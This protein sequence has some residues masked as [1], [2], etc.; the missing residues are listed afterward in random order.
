MNAATAF[1]GGAVMYSPSK[2]RQLTAQRFAHDRATPTINQ[3]HSASGD[4]RSV[5]AI[6]AAQREHRTLPD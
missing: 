4:R 1:V 2:R 3:A 6:E 5:S